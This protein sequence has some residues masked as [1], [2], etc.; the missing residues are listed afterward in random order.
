M[1]SIGSGDPATLLLFIRIINNSDAGFP[2]APLPAGPA[3]EEVLLPFRAAGHGQELPRED[4]AGRPGARD[5]PAALGPLLAALRRPGPAGR[6]H[7]RP[8]GSEG[9]GGD[10]RG[11]EAAHP[12]RRGPSPHRKPR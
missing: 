10:R 1:S 9:V 5:R 11:P 4:P 6:A 2:E 12:A 7:R 8:P 3:G